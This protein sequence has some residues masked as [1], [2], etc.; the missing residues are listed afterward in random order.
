MAQTASLALCVQAETEYGTQRLVARVVLVTPDGLRNPLW[1]WGSDPHTA[2]ADFQV[3]AYLDRDHEHAQCP[4]HSF[5]PLSVEL[6]QAE[7]IARVLRKIRR[8]L[9]AA[10]KDSGYLPAD[11]FAGYL[12]RIAAI[13]RIHTYYVRNTDKGRAISGETFRRTDATGLQYWIAD[14]EKEL[15]KP[16]P[17]PN[18]T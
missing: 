11:D 12:F 3:H 14:R 8:G 9:D 17:E 7:S 16:R 5:N 4:G 6:D 2:L 1:Q 18:A 10:E 13:L 15:G